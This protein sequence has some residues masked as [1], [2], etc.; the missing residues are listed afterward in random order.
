VTPERR[1]AFLVP[2]DIEN[3]ARPSGGNE[4]DRRL[5]AGLRDDGWAVDVRPAAVAPAIAQATADIPDGSVVVVDGLFTAPAVDELVAQATRS[6]LVPLMHMSMAVAPPGHDPSGAAD[7]ERCVLERAA[8]VIATSEWLRRQL[9][10]RQGIDPGRVWAA[11]PGV[12]AAPLA[13][14]SPAG[15]RLL[16]VAPVAPHK[17]HDVL[18]DALARLSDLDWTCTCAGSLDRDPDFATTVRAGAADRGIGDRIAFAGVRTRPE[19]DADYAASDLLVLPTRSESY[20]M[21]LTEA[22][23]R[24]LP[25]VASDVGGVAQAVTGA[26]WR[27]GTSAAVPGTLVPPDDP[28]ALADRLRGW[29]TDAGLR[30]EWRR[31]ARQRRRRLPGWEGTARRAAT[32]IERVAAPRVS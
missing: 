18:V 6:R 1:I 21:V 29:L 26:L 2:D 14:P 19:L 20:G 24:G 11:P 22:L 23:A 17:G 4:Y 7:A 25:V 28:Q 27:A 15:N 9:V 8:A 32:V 10:T 16:C 12:D 13:R 5:A 3:P 30:A 31:R